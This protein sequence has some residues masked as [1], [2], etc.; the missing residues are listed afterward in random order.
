VREED[1]SNGDA[2]KLAAQRE[3]QEELR[4]SVEIEELNFLGAIYADSGGRIA[5]HVALVFEWR[6][7]T[8]DV[9]VTLSTSEFFERRGTSLSGKFVPLETLVKDVEAGDMPE[10][11]SV[12][13]VNQLLPA[14]PT[15]S[16][17]F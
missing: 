7:E 9:A 8:D 10:P 2:I 16:L 13:I 1:A 15:I 11:W 14:A 3:L 6:A 12:E 5:R 17:L 4:L